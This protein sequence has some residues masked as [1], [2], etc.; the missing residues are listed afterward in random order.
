MLHCVYWYVLDHTV[1][2]TC[3]IST[4]LWNSWMK[5]YALAYRTMRNTSICGDKDNYSETVATSTHT[6]TPDFIWPILSLLAGFLI[7]QN[8]TLSGT[9]KSYLLCKHHQ[10]P[11]VNTGVS[12]IPVWYIC[13][14]LSLQNVSFVT[15]YPLEIH[16]GET[17]QESFCVVVENGFISKDEWT[18]RKTVIVLY[19]ILC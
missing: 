16:V 8:N 2:F 15:W 12:H 6:H 13:Y 4:N 14:K 7:I 19:K 17:T 18:P 11:S 1:S 3:R 9:N 10:S 5:F